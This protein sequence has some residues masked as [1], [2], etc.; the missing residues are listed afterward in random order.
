MR[1]TP[2]F[3]PRSFE[4]AYGIYKTVAHYISDST[5]VLLVATH[6]IATLHTIVFL[7]SFILHSLLLS[8]LHRYCR[9]HNS[10]SAHSL[11]N[12]RS[13]FHAGTAWFVV[14]FSIQMSA[15]ALQWTAT[16]VP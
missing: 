16:R 2:P 3:F 13:P 1:F 15:P 4:A 6:G 8:A 14:A 7:T 9:A 11:N 10:P 5:D 12:S